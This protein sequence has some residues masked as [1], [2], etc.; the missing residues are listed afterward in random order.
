VGD[1]VCEETHQTSRAF[2][3]VEGVV[4]IHGHDAMNSSSTL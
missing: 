2:I 4:L 1:L 3:S